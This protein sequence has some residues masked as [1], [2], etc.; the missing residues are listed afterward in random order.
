MLQ[1]LSL[2]LRVQLGAIVPTICI[3]KVVAQPK[4]HKNAPAILR[5][6]LDHISQSYQSS[7]IFQS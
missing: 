2:R 1:S 4:P 3:V 6:E 7:A 5:R